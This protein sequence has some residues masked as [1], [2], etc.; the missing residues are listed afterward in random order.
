MRYGLRLYDEP[1]ERCAYF[2]DEKEKNN[3]NGSITLNYP[4]E[5][6]LIVPLIENK[7]EKQRIKIFFSKCYMKTLILA[8]TLKLKLKCEVHFA[9]CPEHYINPHLINCL[10]DDYKIIFDE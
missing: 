2:G 10:K 5:T 3:E 9:K 1:R 6:D 4:L 7:D 8:F